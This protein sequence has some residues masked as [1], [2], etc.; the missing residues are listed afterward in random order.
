M[1]AA[2]VFAAVLAQ[3]P[4]TPAAVIQPGPQH[5]MMAAAYVPQRVYDTRLKAFT[6]FE[7]ML[8]DLARADVALV[9]EQHDDPNTH[10]LEA[11]V[12]QGL[13]RRGVGVTVS[14]EMFERDVQ[15]VLDG[16]LAGTTAEDDFLKASRPWPRYATDYRTLVE[17]ARGHG[18]PIVAANVP[19]KYAADIAKTGLAAVS[20]LPDPERPL[21][22][23]DLQCPLDAYFDRFAATMSGHPAGEGAAADQRAMVERYYQAQCVKDETMAESIS[24]S[25]DRQSGKRGTIV[26]FTGAFHVDFGGGTAERVRR[27]MPGRRVAIVSIVPVED[28]DAIAIGDEDLKRAEYLVFTIGQS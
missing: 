9:G 16:Y 5:G 24:A 1:Y 3:T 25:F 22:A 23:R 18:W 26:H 19:R 10:R 21:V 6:D 15:P 4:A 7:T 2:L 20:S 11:A 17:M 13:M 12:L 28:L 27:R 8:A 14:L